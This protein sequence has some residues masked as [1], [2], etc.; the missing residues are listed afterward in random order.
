MR[1]I[2]INRF[3]HP[4][5]SATSQLLTDLCFH[6]A[7]AGH[8]V[9]VV[10]S[11]QR[12]EDPG[13]RLPS[14]QLVN[15]VRV[16]RIAT[17]RFGRMRLAGRAIDY[18][19]FYVSAWWRLA[20]I[21]R[22]G[23]V[24]VAETD[25]PL[26]SVVAASVCRLRG[27]AL[28]N[29]VQD[30]F[31]E[32]AQR[33]G[34]RGLGG[35]IG[36]LLA[37]LRDRSLRAAAANVALSD[38]MAGELRRCAPAAPTVVVHNWSDGSSVRPVEREAN[39]LR[40]EWSLQGRFVVGYSGNMGRAHDFDTI[41]DAC[42]RLRAR[43]DIAFLFVGGGP[44]HAHVRAQCEARGLRN[45]HFRPFQPRENLASSLGVADVHIVSLRPA[46]DGLIVPSKFYGI[47]A[48]GRATLFIGRAAGDLASLIAAHGVGI[49]V[50]SGDPESLARAVE[51]LADAADRT[52]RMGEDARALFEARFDMTIALAQWRNLIDALGAGADG[53]HRAEGGRLLL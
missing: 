19:T 53:T 17:T 22:Q 40:E 28:V 50:E 26:I 21:V 30:L 43:G 2:F 41:L 48:A 32:V 35:P 38:G 25:P 16:H 47:A 37:A 46:L 9:H 15:G 24:V 36:A 29:W 33:L 20:A 18:L 23:D 3:F 1:L 5:E 11:R 8:D 49:A 7:A 52:R 4:D 34:V 42:E 13:A 44:Q 12:H 31:P 14:A 6:L 51:S 27:A 39:P 45:A 10:A